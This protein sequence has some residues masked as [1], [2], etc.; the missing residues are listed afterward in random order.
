[1][2]S[3]NFVGNSKELWKTVTTVSNQGRMRGRAKGLMR[4]KDLNRGQKMGFGKN[5]MV[6]PGLTTAIKTK[7]PDSTKVEEMSKE[8]YEQYLDQRFVSNTYRKN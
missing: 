7:D 2:Y 6:F 3:P 1:M 8:S 5:R 4:I